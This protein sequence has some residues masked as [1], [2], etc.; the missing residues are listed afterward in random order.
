MISSLCRTIAG[1]IAFWAILSCGSDVAA[2]SAG[3]LAT[4]DE[5]IFADGFELRAVITVPQDGDPPRPADVPIPFVG[6]AGEPATLVWTSSIE[7]QI[8]TGES[9]SALLSVGVHTIT[10]TATNAG[11]AVATDQVTVTVVQP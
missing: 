8:G 1:M 9:F 3:P 4:Q 7:G 5:S 10:L 2:R 6:S 11:G